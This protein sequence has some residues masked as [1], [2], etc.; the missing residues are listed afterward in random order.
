ML[1]LKTRGKLLTI[2]ISIIIVFSIVVNLV[3]Y[4][5][6]SNTVNLITD[7]LLKTNANLGF[8]TIENKYTGDWKVEQGKL[9]KGSQPMNDNFDIVDE[10]KKDAGIECTIFLNDTRISTTVLKDGKRAVGTKAEAK[11]VQKVINEGIEYIGSATIVEL[12]YKTIYMPIKDKSNKTIGMF[13]VGIQKQDID[14]DI[15]RVVSLITLI[16]LAMLLIASLLILLTTSRVI[17]N[18]IRYIQK[19]LKVIASGDL[20]ED[21]NSVYLKKKDE[22]GDIVNYM[23][24]MQDSLRNVTS[25]I[26]KSSD[27]IDAESESL[28]A[29]SEQMAATAETVTNA[30][31]EVAKGAGSQAEELLKVLAILDKFGEQLNGIVKAIKNIDTNSKDINSSVNDS[32]E[33]IKSLLESVEII[34]GYFNNFNTKIVGLGQSITQINEITDFISSITDQTNLLALNAAIEAAR[35]GEAGKGFSVVADEIRKLAEQSKESME[36]INQLVKGISEN[37]E[38]MLQDAG[39]ISGEL[40]NQNQ[41]INTATSSYEKMIGAVKA[42][43]PK[44]EAV[45]KLINDLEKGKDNIIVQITSVSSIAEEASAASQEIAASSEQMNASTEEVASSAQN[46][47]GM[48]NNMQKEVKRFKL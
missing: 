38:T 16:T 8:Q 29:V 31:Q 46:L 34:G 3:V 15:K 40:G 12:P 37:A 19:H 11:V 41:V 27:A 36:S 21:I 7:D 18:P 45:D 47:N 30:I 17:I 22:I 43:G 6:F 23:K 24:E 4:L 44:I 20:S 10:I 28:S 14:N 35:A 26:K 25:N 2:I 48:I 9:Y 13:F 32:N 5:E 33:S 1:I 42:I 39:L